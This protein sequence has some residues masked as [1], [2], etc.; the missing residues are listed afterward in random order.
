[1]W[2]ARRG[3]RFEQAP[4]VGRAFG[5]PALGTGVVDAGIEGA[6][7]AAQ[8]VERHG[9]DHVRRARERF[10]IRQQE[11]ADGEHG[12]GAIDQGNALLGLQRERRD[13]GAGQ[14]FAAGQHGAV[15]FGFALPGEHQCH[16]GEGGEV[17]ARRPRCRARE[18]PG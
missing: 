5:L 1:M 16:V 12:L 14:G 15:P 10:G 4:E 11:A 3:L 18:P 7:G 9:A 6:R 13:A 17:A 2:E 8:G